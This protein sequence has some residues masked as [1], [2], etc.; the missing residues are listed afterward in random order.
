M[1]PHSLVLK[2]ASV[3]APIDT[4]DVEVIVSG[5]NNGTFASGTLTA[6]DALNGFGKGITDVTN[7]T[8]LGDYM[9][10]GG[11]GMKYTV[12]KEF[13]KGK[14]NVWT[15]TLPFITSGDNVTEYVL[16]NTN[17]TK[18]TQE[19]IDPDA[20]SNNKTWNGKP[21]TAYPDHWKL[22][23]TKNGVDNVPSVHPWAMVLFKE[24]W[25]GGSKTPWTVKYT[26]GEPVEIK[27]GDQYN[28]KVVYIPTGQVMYSADVI[29]GSDA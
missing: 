10:Y 29:V 18:A 13:I 25:S 12:E 19:I 23:N 6:G 15:K 5:L 4:N 28:I 1:T 9:L 24:G 14:G 7:G 2:V 16:D 21:D 22:G 20:G 26:E 8:R 11:T 17:L 27:S 3:S